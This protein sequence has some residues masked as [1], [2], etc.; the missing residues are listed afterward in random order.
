[1]CDTGSIWLECVVLIFNKPLLVVL[2]IVIQSNVLHL[3]LNKRSTCLKLH[4]L[5]TR[6]EFCVQCLICHICCLVFPNVLFKQIGFVHV[7][8]SLW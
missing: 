1:M 7:V 2:Y 8:F 3:Y 5:I 4:L 6:V